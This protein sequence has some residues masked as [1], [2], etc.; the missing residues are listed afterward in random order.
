M[1][2]T[3]SA[4]AISVYQSGFNHGVSDAKCASVGCRE[5]IIQ[6]GK[7]FGFHIRDF[8]NGYVN[9]YC[10]IAMPPTSKAVDAGLDADEAKVSHVNRAQV[11]RS[12]YRRAKAFQRAL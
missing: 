9:G 4:F 8:I 12:G 3:P 6:P 5:Y 1:T 7:G 11:L 2:L 10:S